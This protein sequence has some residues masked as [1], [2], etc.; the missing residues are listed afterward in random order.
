MMK[1]SQNKKKLRSSRS[2]SNVR[3]GEKRQTSPHTPS[4]MRRC[5]TCIATGSVVKRV[6]TQRIRCQRPGWPS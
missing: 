4:A 2:F 3:K 5:T 6:I 1:Y